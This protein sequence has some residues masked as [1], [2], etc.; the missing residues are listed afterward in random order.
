MCSTSSTIRDLAGRTPIPVTPLSDVLRLR[1]R[2]RL[3]AWSWA[4]ESHSERLCQRSEQR[5]LAVIGRSG[6]RTLLRPSTAQTS[7]ASVFAYLMQ[8]ADLIRRPIHKY[9]FSVDE[10]ARD[11][12][13]GAAVVR[14]APM[15]A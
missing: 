1:S 5:A 9:R 7:S 13:P 15:V 8:D 11:H 6:P 4:E 10:A 3:G 14:G 2:T 12:S